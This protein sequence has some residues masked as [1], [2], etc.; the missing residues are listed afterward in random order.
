MAIDS[1]NVFIGAPDQK[2]TGAILTGPETDVV[3]ESIDDFDFAGLK[4]SGYV[5]TDGVKVT[6]S[7]ST[8]SIKDWSGAE[9]RRIVSEFT[10]DISWSHLDLSAEAMRNYFGDDNVAISDATATVGAQTRAAL[11]G[12]IQPVKA[13]YFKIKDG[14]R[15]MLVFVPH[16]QVTARGEIPLQ[17]TAAITLPVT[18]STYPDADGNNIYFFTDDGQKITAGP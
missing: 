9:I 3:P 16:G 7:E 15:R 18:V 11:S 6:P 8:E 4:D 13:W 2:A 10:G 1:K 17:S 12:K 14:D 5:S